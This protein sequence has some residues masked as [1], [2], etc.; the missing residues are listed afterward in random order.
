[1][2]MCLRPTTTPGLGTIVVKY[3]ANKSEGLGQ[4]TCYVF[5][6][7]Q[8]LGL[9]YLQNIQYKCI[10]SMLRISAL[11]APPLIILQKCT[12][13]LSK[14]YLLSLLKHIHKTPQFIFLRSE[15]KMTLF[16]QFGAMKHSNNCLKEMSRFGFKSTVQYFPVYISLLQLLTML[17]ISSGQQ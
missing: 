6:Q 7:G 16:K 15:I 10:Y 13:Y 5:C 8:I 2:K 4:I 11:Y 14:D 12:H 1:M 9:Y 3:K 17:L